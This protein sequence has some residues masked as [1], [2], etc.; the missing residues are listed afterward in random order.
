MESNLTTS[1]II[2]MII[3]WGGVGALLVLTMS[4]VLRGENK[5]D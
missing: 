5:L 3:G 4:K 1:G 2:F